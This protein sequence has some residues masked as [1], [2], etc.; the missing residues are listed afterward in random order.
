MHVIVQGHTEEM[1]ALISK[2][3][4]NLQSFTITVVVPVRVV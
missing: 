2:D 3:K 1:F 4:I